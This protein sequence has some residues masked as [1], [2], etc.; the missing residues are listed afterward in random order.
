MKYCTWGCNIM[1]RLIVQDGSKWLI[2]QVKNKNPKKIWIFKTKSWRGGRPQRWAMVVVHNKCK[3][4]LDRRPVWETAQTARLEHDLLPSKSFPP[5]QC[6]FHYKITK[7]TKPHVSSCRSKRANWF[8]T[9]EGWIP[10]DIKLKFDWKHNIPLS[11]NMLKIQ[12]MV[13]LLPVNT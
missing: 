12:N 4:G 7:Y 11:I 6:K 8:L 13:I 2:L 1:G 3:E 9:K 10:S 5:R